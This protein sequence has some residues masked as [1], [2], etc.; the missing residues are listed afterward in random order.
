MRTETLRI[1]K[2]TDSADTTGHLFVDANISYDPRTPESRTE[3]IT[4]L[5]ASLIDSFTPDSLD[6]T[7]GTIASPAPH[8]PESRYTQY[9]YSVEPVL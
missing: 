1:R 5:F 4:R 8:N 9:S 7:A 2:H 3:A 6:I